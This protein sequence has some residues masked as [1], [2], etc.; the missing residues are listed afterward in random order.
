[1]SSNNLNIGLHLETRELAFCVRV[2]K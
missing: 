1:M 2:N